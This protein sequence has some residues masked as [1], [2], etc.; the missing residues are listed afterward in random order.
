MK[1]PH[2]HDHSSLPRLPQFGLK[3]LLV[4]IAIVSV[5]FTLMSLIG[6]VWSAVSAWILMLVGAHVLG[7]AWG[8][9]AFRSPPTSSEDGTSHSWRGPLP[10]LQ[11]QRAPLAEATRGGLPRVVACIASAVSLGAVGGAVLTFLFWRQASPSAVFVW[12][13]SLGVVGGL[14]GFIASGFIQVFGVIA[15]ST[16]PD[17]IR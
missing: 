7:N 16:T 9:R 15:E 17:Q 13:A 11:L 3:A 8:S 14:L 5:W 12:A 4:F 10:P 1:L 6:A 2:L